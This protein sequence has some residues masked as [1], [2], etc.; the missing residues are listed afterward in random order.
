MLEGI[1]LNKLQQKYNG[2]SN[3]QFKKSDMEK[4]SIEN[5]ETFN[6]ISHVAVADTVK[7]K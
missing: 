7:R 3:I 4:F 1:N 5:T 2:K 6:E